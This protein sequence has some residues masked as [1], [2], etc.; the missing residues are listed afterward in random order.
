MTTAI[1]DSPHGG[2]H[3]DG[4]EGDDAKGKYNCFHLVA[5]GVGAVISGNF[6]GWQNC[7]VGGLG[8][9]LVALVPITAMYA[10]LSLSIAELCAVLPHADGPF[11]FLDATLGNRAALAAGFAETVKIVA[12]CAVVVDGMASYILGGVLSSVVSE[13]TVTSWWIDPVLWIALTVI[14]T[15]ANSFGASTSLALQVGMFIA[16]MAM[17]LAFY[18]VAAVSPEGQALN[19]TRWGLTIF[20]DPEQPN[21]LETE[22]FPVGVWMGSV[23]SLPFCLW[24]YLG[25]EELPLVESLARDPKRD[26]PRALVS[27]MAILMVV[28][29]LTLFIS[30]SLPPGVPVLLQSSSP[31]VSEERVCL[32]ASPPRQCPPLSA[33]VV[34]S[35]VACCACEGNFAAGN[36]LSPK[37]FPSR[38]MERVGCC[39]WRR[40]HD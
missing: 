12:T 30:I 40:Q 2:K 17:L 9:T 27:T 37:R 23:L 20:N 5:L 24:F 10:L 33:Q 18:I 34:T 22:Y 1:D 16:T 21:S 36:I 35:S 31:M 28:A 15:T 19:L 25:I 6:F 32:F 14:F 7:L 3:N 4:H 11:G 38:D 26:M 8:G 13:A 29:L 39:W